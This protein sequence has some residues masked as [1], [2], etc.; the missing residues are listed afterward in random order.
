MS[1]LDLVMEV[2]DDDLTKMYQSGYLSGYMEAALQA[3]SGRDILGM[4]TDGTM[5]M[6]GHVADIMAE[7][8]KKYGWTLVR[9]DDADDVPSGYVE[10]QL[11]RAK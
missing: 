9:L 2:V 5:F 1:D 10:V 6:L 3:E 7:H 8:F 11:E 4:T